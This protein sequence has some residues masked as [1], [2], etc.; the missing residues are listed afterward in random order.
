M[1]T[2]THIQ[3]RDRH[4]LVL[5]NETL[6][7]AALHAAVQAS[8]LCGGRVL[9]VAP[10]LNQRLRHWLSDSDGARA[11]AQKRLLACLEALA[12][13]GVN[14]EGMIGDADP[15]Q[16]ALDA[17]ASFNADEIVVA[18]HPE[19]QSNWLARGL[20]DRLCESSNL[21]VLHVVV[22]PEPVPANRLRFHRGFSGSAATMPR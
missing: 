22:R 15:L 10:A 3:A 4:I 14:A 2:R 20:V 13:A 12:A 1:F 16:A 6:E 5:A 19:E 18:T 17:L 7:G 21:P 8:A 9:V 11:A